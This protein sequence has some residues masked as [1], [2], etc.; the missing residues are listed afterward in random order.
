[1][2]ISSSNNGTGVAVALFY[3]AAAA[4]LTLELWLEPLLARWSRQPPALVLMPVALA[5]AEKR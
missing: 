4:V 5:I 1:M 3:T 2:R